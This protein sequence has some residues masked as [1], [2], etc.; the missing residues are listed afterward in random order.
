MNG[1]EKY[2]K[3]SCFVFPN[4]F[5]LELQVKICTE[6]HYIAKMYLKGFSK[7]MLPKKNQDYPHLHVGHITLV[8]GDLLCF[9]LV[10]V[11][12]TT[13]LVDNKHG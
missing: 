6:L 13:T 1:K 8:K 5:E 9:S 4:G 7:C 12:Y 10:F 3:N 2:H 11:I